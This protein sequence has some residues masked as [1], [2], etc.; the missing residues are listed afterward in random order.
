MKESK[1]LSVCFEVRCWTA[2]DKGAKPGLCSEAV[3][4]LRLTSFAQ[5]TFSPM[6]STAL[7]DV[8][9]SCF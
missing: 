5:Y 4:S 6:Q 3:C 1:Y 7:E 8:L 9:L 2:H